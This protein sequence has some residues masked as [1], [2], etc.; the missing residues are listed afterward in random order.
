LEDTIKTNQKAKEE[1]QKKKKKKSRLAWQN[2][3]FV[4]VGDD[5]IRAEDNE[6]WY[7][8]RRKPKRLGRNCCYFSRR[9]WRV[10]EEETTR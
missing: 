8:S 2:T 3:F 5:G 10:W 4:V 6:C 7:F 9:H 1:K